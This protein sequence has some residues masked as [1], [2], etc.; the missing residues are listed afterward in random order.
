MQNL[1]GLVEIVLSFPEISKVRHKRL[2]LNH[3]EGRSSVGSS[4]ETEGGKPQNSFKIMKAESPFG[5]KSWKI[6]EPRLG[7]TVK[8]EF[9]K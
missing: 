1:E 3:P 8:S 2:Q 7:I 4:A 9:N 6:D 5:P